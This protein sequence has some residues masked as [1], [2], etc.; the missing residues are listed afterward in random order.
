[1]SNNKNS[2]PS[3]LPGKTLG[4][5]LGGTKMYARVFNEK[6][7]PIGTDRQPT[8]GHRGTEKGVQR[9]I[10]VMKA[11]L[12]DANVDASELV[13]IG[14]GCPG[15]I[16]I[17]EG[18]LRTTPNLGW[19]DVPIRKVL[20]KEFGV[21]VVVANDVDAGTYG[22]YVAGAGMGVRSLLGVFPG[23][24]VGAGF[25]YDGKVFQGSRF[26]A[27]EIGRV[28]WP[29]AALISAKGEYPTVEA[30][31]SRLAI[32][33]SAAA[34]AFRGRAPHLMKKTGAD[35]LKIKSK[36]L[37]QSYAAKDEGTRAVIDNALDYLAMTVGTAVNMLAP[38]RIVLGGGL[39]EAMPDVFVKG[40]RKRVC[41][42]VSEEYVEELEVV[43]AELGDDAAAVGAAAMVAAV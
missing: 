39:A 9:I 24:G 20:E 37:M 13:G 1:M 43:V 4:F 14:I 35:L 8:E 2:F 31:C 29:A 32:A 11:A 27:M 34:E 16:D 33:S 41:K 15:V 26:S 22:E 19:D 10:E 18:I 40:L 30:Y 21:K 28:R 17:R 12:A 36:A 23:T 42:H 5:D 6:L 3:T 25:V 38:D 7:K